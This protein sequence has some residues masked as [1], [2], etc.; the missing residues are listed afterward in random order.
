MDLKKIIFSLVSADGVSGNEKNAAE[1]ALE[2]LKKYTD[3]AFI[4]NGNVIGH[5]GE[6]SEGKPHIL[7]DAHIDQ[8]GMI[9]SYI[10]DDGFIKAGNIGGLDRRILAAQQVTVHGRENIAGIICSVP[11]HLSDGESKVPSMGEFSIDTGYSKEEL[12]KIVSVGD[13]IS[14]ASGFRELVNNR[15][16]GHSL[17]DRCGVAAIL[18]MLELLKNE[19]PP[20]SLTILFSSQEEVGERGAVIAVNEINP[21]IAIAVDVSFA[22]SAG[23]SEEKCGKTGGGC[24]I[25][26]APVLDR[27]ISSEL[28]AIAEDKEIPYQI[29]VMGGTTGTNADRFSIAGNGVRTVT[30][31]IPLRYMHTPAEVIEISDVENTAVLLAEYIRRCF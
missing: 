21:D 12:E 28:I 5:I 4:K 14:F 1:T 31:S 8:I 17:D 29:E 3:N 13:T 18:Y 11:P 16:C 22:L 24:M 23:E 20:C 10:S 6:R 26:I 15:I 19:N 2:L 7:V 9:C 25:G 27:K 30:C